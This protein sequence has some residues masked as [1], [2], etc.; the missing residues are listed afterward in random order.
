MIAKSIQYTG[1]QIQGGGSR[2]VLVCE[3]ALGQIK[4]T[5]K[6]NNDFKLDEG[7]HSVWGKGRSGPDSEG[8]ASMVTLSDGAV[9]PIGKV[10]NFGDRDRSDFLHSEYVIP[11]SS[12]VRLR[13]LLQFK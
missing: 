7:F 2:Y 1:D 13:Y 9:V 6:T 8:S 4:E 3:V 11:D 10:K 5:M 12:Q